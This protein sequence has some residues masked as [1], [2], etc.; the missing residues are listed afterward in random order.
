M[1]D[2]PLQMVS[3][4]L[5]NAFFGCFLFFEDIQI[6]FLVVFDALQVNPGGQLV[7]ITAIEGCELC[8]LGT[9]N[10]WKCEP[11]E[12]PGGGGFGGGDIIIFH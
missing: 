8:Y 9:G 5:H 11:V 1:I 4:D 3:N 6:A 2:N 10:S 7:A 12:Q